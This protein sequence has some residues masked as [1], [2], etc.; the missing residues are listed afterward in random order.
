MGDH[1]LN[2]EMSLVGADGVERKAELWVNWNEERPRDVIKAL[3]DLADRSQMPAIW[4]DEYGK[5]GDT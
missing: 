3:M 4:P 1:R 2:V 5:W